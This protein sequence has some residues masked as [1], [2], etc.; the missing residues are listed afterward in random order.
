MFEIHRPEE[1]LTPDSA[2]LVSALVVISDCR[3]AVN[4]RVRAEAHRT[5]SVF[6][7][8]RGTIACKP[9]T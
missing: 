5:G 4:S 1:T 3:R 9:H 8:I 6:A 2:V 7:I